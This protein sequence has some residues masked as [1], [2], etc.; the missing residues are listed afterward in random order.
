MKKKGEFLVSYTRRKNGFIKGY[1]NL[2]DT[3]TF[4][5]ALPGPEFFRIGPLSK[6]N[7]RLIKKY[8]HILE[9]GRVPK[10]LKWDPMWDCNCI[11]DC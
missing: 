11:S 10:N 2:P 1:W 3:D 5:E 4:D 8:L 7:R 6:I 9:N